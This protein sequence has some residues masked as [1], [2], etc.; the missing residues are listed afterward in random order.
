MIYRQDVLG[1][2]R[3]CG[4]CVK[5]GMELKC[6][7]WDRKP[8]KYLCEVPRKAVKAGLSCTVSSL[9]QPQH[10]EENILDTTHYG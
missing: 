4:Q 5:R 1:N 2:E 9:Q 6:V 8:P 10:H 7:D 3:P